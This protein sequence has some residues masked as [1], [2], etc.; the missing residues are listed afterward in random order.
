MESK[1]TRAQFKIIDVCKNEKALLEFEDSLGK[2]IHLGCSF[3]CIQHIK[4]V[5]PTRKIGQRTS[6]RQL[7]HQRKTSTVKSSTI[8]SDDL[9][10]LFCH[11]LGIRIIG[12][13]VCFN[14][15][16][17]YYISFDP[18]LVR[19][20]ESHVSHDAQKP[21]LLAKEILDPKYFIDEKDGKIKD[22]TIIALDIARFCKIA[23]STMGIVLPSILVSKNL[24]ID[25]KGTYNYVHRPKYHLSDP[26]VALWLLRQ[27]EEEYSMEHLV[28]KYLYQANHLMDQKSDDRL[29]NDVVDNLLGKNGDSKKNRGR[30]KNIP[31]SCSSKALNPS[32]STTENEAINYAIAEAYICHSVTPNIELDLQNY[33]LADAYHRVEMPAL[34]VLVKR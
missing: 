29:L 1:N 30:R 6:R 7:E 26:R 23:H 33:K 2:A 34:S 31:T 10:T 22:R 4:E 16:T 11:S 18:P 9:D 24:K 13:A 3:A 8:K 25:H 32:I 5:S 21:V 17:V 15:D 12:M 14:K 28:Y 20:L 19:N 27:G